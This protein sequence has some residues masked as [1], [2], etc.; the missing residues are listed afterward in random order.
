V[1]LPDFLARGGDGL[2]PVTRA[3]PPE[4]VDIRAQDLREALIAYGKARGGL[5]APPLGR[6]RYMGVA[7]CGGTS[8]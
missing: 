2:G 4:R 8:R 7:D 3:L 5:S 1:A 6:I